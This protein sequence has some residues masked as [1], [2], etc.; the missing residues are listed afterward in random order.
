MEFTRELLPGARLMSLKKFSDQRGIFVKTFSRSVFEEYGAAF[1]FSEEFYSSSRKDV[2]RGMHFQKPPYDH[3]KLVYCA[4]GAVLD[5]LVDLRRGPGQGRVANVLL[6]A[7][8]PAI[9]VIPSGIA[10][11]F[12][13][14]QDDSLMVYKTSTEYSPSHD[15]GVLWDSIGFDWNIAHPIVSARDSA[16]TALADF[17][18]P[19]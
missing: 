19:F 11:G 8:E 2:V 4:A 10:H 7:D 15:A 16:H 17:I 13:S 14:L 5:V 18:S 3:V 6:S 9:L 12:K 1:E